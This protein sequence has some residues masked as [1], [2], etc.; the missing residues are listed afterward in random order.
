MLSGS[1]QQNNHAQ[2][3]QGELGNDLY[4]QR[5]LKSVLLDGMI[6]YNGWA[7]MLSYMS[8]TTS[9]NANTVNPLNLTQTNYVFVGNGLDYQLS[10]ITKNNYEFIGRFSTQKVGTEI[11]NFVPNTKEFTLGFN[12]YIWEHTFKLQ[13]ELTFDKLNYLDGTTKNNWYLRFQ[14]EIGI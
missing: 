12:K 13:S 3:S 5:T 6:K 9:E 7:A 14:V 2:R 10:Y 8:R 11:K 1:F 4:E